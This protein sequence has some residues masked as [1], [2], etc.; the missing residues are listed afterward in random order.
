MIRAVESSKLKWWHVRWK[1][2]ALTLLIAF[3]SIYL[4]GA[5]WEEIDSELRPWLFARQMSK[6]QPN[7]F[8]LAK[9]IDPRTSKLNGDQ[10]D[11]F[12]L[13]LQFPWGTP[14]IRRK[15][16]A[17]MLSIES[18]GSIAILDP[19]LDLAPLNGG[20][21]RW[22]AAMNTTPEDIK[23]W[24]LRR[25]NARSF[26]LLLQKS[27]ALHDSNVPYSVN[28]GEM[29]GFQQGDPSRS[30]YRVDLDLFDKND[31]HYMIVIG[32]ADENRPSISQAQINAMIS[33]MKSGQY[34]SGTQH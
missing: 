30:P 15:K 22:N 17:C 28:F 23:W 33:S 13:S 12:G 32:S 4:F 26:E 10:V 2:P 29:R 18:R 1:R 14:A 3:C 27:I 20:Y 8:A 11:C 16:S 21:E 9:P 19:S 7:L 5:A 6:E 25:W 31:R 34:T 24:R